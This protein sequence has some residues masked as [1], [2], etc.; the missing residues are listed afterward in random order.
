MQARR[1]SGSKAAI[2]DLS[3]A[4]IHDLSLRLVTNLALL[5]AIFSSW[6]LKN[7]LAIDRDCIREFLDESVKRGFAAIGRNAPLVALQSRFLRIWGHAAQ[8]N[9]Q[10]TRA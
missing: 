7:C 2:H 9:A 1:S 6:T 5:G 10:E 8:S 4:A 3:K